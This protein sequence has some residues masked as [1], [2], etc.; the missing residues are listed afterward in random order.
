M[1]EDFGK[2]YEEYFERDRESTREV[3]GDVDHS[4]SFYS[5][6]MPGST[7]SFSVRSARDGFELIPLLVNLVADPSGKLVEL[8]YVSGLLGQELDKGV[9][10]FNYQYKG[11][12]SPLTY[13]LLRTPSTR[14]MI[15]Q[16]TERWEHFYLSILQT[17][18]SEEEFAV[19]LQEFSKGG[20]KIFV[21]SE[22][23]WLAELI[24]G[25]SKHRAI[26]RISER[27]LQESQD[28]TDF[29]HRSFHKIQNYRS[30][31]HIPCFYI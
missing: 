14:E 10:P 29:L 30:Y 12:I 17:E 13:E 1:E 28:H 8:D 31:I 25:L 20:E 2:V 3:V 5:V 24:I 26:E 4:T 22:I 23:S 18:V 9:S 6:L 21:Q 11:G 15:D 19:R 27:N 16:F 7:V